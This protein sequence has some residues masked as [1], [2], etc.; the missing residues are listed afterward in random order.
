MLK[1]L[2]TL[3]FEE[4]NGA[5]R[6]MPMPINGQQLKKA[7]GWR[8]GPEMGSILKSL[9]DAFRRGEWVTYEEGLKKADQLKRKS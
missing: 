9:R 6:R 4:K 8:E 5:L 7:F 1:S 3:P 2:N